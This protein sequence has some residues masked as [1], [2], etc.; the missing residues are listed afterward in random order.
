MVL[1]QAWRSF[2]LGVKVLMY[3]VAV[4][5]RALFATSLWQPRCYTRAGGQFN[6]SQVR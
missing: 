5:C 4:R 6:V 3:T 1:M 2:A